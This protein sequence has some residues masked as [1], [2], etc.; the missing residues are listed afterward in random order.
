MRCQKLNEQLSAYIDGMLDSSQVR[1]VE[2]HLQECTDCREE[3]E[4]LKVAVKLVRELPEVVPPPEFRANLGRKLQHLPP[5]VI[6]VDSV[7]KSFFKRWYGIVTAAA[8]LFIVLGAVTWGSGQQLKSVMLGFMNEIGQRT[9]ISDPGLK[10]IDELMVAYDGD[11][12]VTTDNEK[13][14]TGEDSRTP[15]AGTDEKSGATA[16]H[17]PGGAEGKLE[18]RD[19]ETDPAPAPQPQSVP[20]KESNEATPMSVP[21]GFED[22]PESADTGQ[23]LQNEAAADQGQTNQDMHMMR[24]FSQEQETVQH[25]DD[26]VEPV[27]KLKNNPQEDRSLAVINYKVT[28]KTGDQDA[29]NKLIEKAAGYGGKIKDEAGQTTDS[30]VLFMPVAQVEPF[31]KDIKRLG[32]VEYQQDSKDV[33]DAY[34]QAQEVFLALLKQEQALLG[35]PEQTVSTGNQLAAL[36]QQIEAQQRKLVQLNESIEQAEIELMIIL[37]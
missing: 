28:L 21:R 37:K 6:H 4:E 7:A 16:E 2:E 36:K 19:D 20:R 14:Y 33:T 34:M 10:D 5:P 25:P 13:K 15:G 24:A 17:K 3:Y 35:E 29:S 9:E 8:V 1:E 23:M 22:A 26:P 32:K 31:L 27:R 30:K 11:P 12:T 18:L